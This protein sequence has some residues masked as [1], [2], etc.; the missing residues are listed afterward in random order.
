MNNSITQLEAEEENRIIEAFR[1]VG[2]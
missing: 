2:K 1:D